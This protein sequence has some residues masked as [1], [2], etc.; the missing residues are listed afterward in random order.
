MMPDTIDLAAAEGR[1]L[2]YGHRTAILSVHPDQ[3]GAMCRRLTRTLR[4]NL[5]QVRG[6]IVANLSDGHRRLL[7]EFG[8]EIERIASGD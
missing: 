8:V 5:D 4:R 7:H 3:R 2:A 1:A 6:S